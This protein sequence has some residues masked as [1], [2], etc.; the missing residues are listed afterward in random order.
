MIW[1]DKAPDRP[2]WWWY[3][4]HEWDN[5]KPIPEIIL[6]GYWDGVDELVFTDIGKRVSEMPGQW[7][8]EPIPE[9][10]GE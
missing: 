6:I 1:T 7:S 3:S 8:S 4:G 10:E 9:P 2:G 5:E